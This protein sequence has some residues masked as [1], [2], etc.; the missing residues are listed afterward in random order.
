MQEQSSKKKKKP[1][2]L[3]AAHGRGWDKMQPKSKKTE[4]KGVC[5]SSWGSGTW[6]MLPTQ[7]MG[8]E[9]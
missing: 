4:A 7:R 6:Q 5:P 9:A 8:A 2:Q 1:F 3:V